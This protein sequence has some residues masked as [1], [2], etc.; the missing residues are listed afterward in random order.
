MVYA[1]LTG[2]ASDA[3]HLE[4]QQADNLVDFM[5][6]AESREALKAM[7]DDR[8]NPETYQVSRVAERL[9]ENRVASLCT[10]TL[11]WGL[12][13]APHRSDLDIHTVVDGTELYYANMQVGKCTLDFD[14]N[15]SSIEKNPAEN[16]SLNQ[17][18]TFEIMGQ[19]V[20]PRG[21]RA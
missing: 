18:G 12:D 9:R 20:G 5:D 19:E 15:A 11:M 10:V 4:M 14:A 21:G 13:G 2:R 1:M 7:M 3:V 17:V 16:I 8:S 6:S